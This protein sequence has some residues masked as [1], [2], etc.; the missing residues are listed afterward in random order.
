MPQKLDDISRILSSTPSLVQVEITDVKEYESSQEIDL[1]IGSFLQITDNNGAVIIAVIQSYKLIDPPFD[2]DRE[3]TLSLDAQPV[4]SIQ[5]GKFCRGIQRMSI[6][7]SKV[8]V[9][10]EE[11][12]QLMYETELPSSKGIDP[13]FT[14]GR[15]A[16]NEEVRPVLN[17]DR[18]FNKHV[19]VV[20]A[21]G[22][23][24]SCTVAKVLQEGMNPKDLGEGVLN[25]SHI[26]VF[27]IHGEY[28][29]AF[30]S[31]NILSVEKLRLPYWLMNSE[32][33]EEMFIESNEQNSHNQVSQFRHAVIENKKHHNTNLEKITYDT[34][35]YF[36]I[37]EVLNYI[38]N[39]N[40]EVIGKQDGEGY[41]KKVNSEGKNN[42]SDKNED[43]QLITDR[44]AVYFTEQ[45]QFVQTSQSKSEKASVGP[46]NGEFNR[47]IRR[48]E[49]RV[50]DERL[51]F[52]MKAQKQDGNEFK[53]EDFESLL[54]RLAG[55]QDGESLPNSN[56]TIIDLAGIPFEETSIVVSLVS[57]IL[58]EFSFYFKR[59]RAENP[60]EASEPEVP[61]LVVYEE[62]HKYVPN[63]SLVKYSAVRTA[64]ERIAKEGR[65]YGISLLIASQRPSEISETIFSQCSNFIAMRLTNPNDQSYVKRLLPDT[66][67]NITESLPAL[68]RR[69][70]ILIGDAVTMPSLVIVDEI[71]HK[72]ISRDVPVM[73]E[74]R[75]QWFELDFEPIV[76]SMQR[77]KKSS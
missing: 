9:V 50:N 71:E 26:V 25:N 73:T 32:E 48:L 20:G 74:W 6:P 8:E 75:K 17:G 63:S 58:F 2:S 31:A 72:P 22:S 30:P 49:A 68:E 56:V 39:M 27:D 55:Y 57:R 64:I 36:S 13:N 65:K 12:L 3:R 14:I 42:S 77:R 52:M 5:G 44:E 10:S 43:G 24:K 34:P 47:F 18:F 54:R 11:T 23:G 76:G 67:S 45:V 70:A 4:G 61:I 51:D 29:S 1:Q 59:C 37:V 19:A 62:A 46:F 40:N 28:S 21:T 53:T 69:E 15:L 60:D 33:L 16:F 66:I 41:P 35:V 38:V 7:P